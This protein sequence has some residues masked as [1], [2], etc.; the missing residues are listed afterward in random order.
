M[1]LLL[2][3]AVTLLL[4]G[5]GVTRPF[6]SGDGPPARPR[7]VSNVPDA[8][9]R[10]EP[11][12]R[13][14]NPDSYEVH[15]RRYQVLESADGFVQRGIASWYGKKFHGKR[16]SSG[17]P[18]NMYAMTAAHKTLPLPSYVTVK[19]LRNGREVTVKVNDRGPFVDNRIIDLSYA[20]AAKLGMLKTGTAPVEIRLAGTDRASGSD[21]TA[22]PETGK[23]VES[24]DVAYFLQLGAFSQRGNAERLRAR[25]EAAQSATDVRVTPLHRDDAP[26]LYRVRV[27]PLDS[28]DAVDKMTQRLAS[29]GMLNTQVVVE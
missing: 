22:E 8:V 3:T 28:V 23:S 11:R 19:N 29:H 5:C 16:T 21:T 12:S 24:G 2:L 10:D 17:E 13:Y 18:Y 25:A 9:P 1:R 14:G 26:D 7:D 20:A 6:G 27:G 4:A 15:G